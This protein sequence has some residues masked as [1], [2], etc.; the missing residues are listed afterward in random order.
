MIKVVLICCFLFCSF[1]IID[2]YAPFL[3]MTSRESVLN[4]TDQVIAAPGPGHYDPGFPQDLIKV[5]NKFIC[6]VNLRV[7]VYLEDKT[8]LKF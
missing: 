4:P 2:G 1:C 5:S 7:L 6:T 3:S 8:T